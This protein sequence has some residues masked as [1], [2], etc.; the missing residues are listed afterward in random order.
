M[1]T[2]MTQET[3]TKLFTEMGFETESRREEFNRAFDAIDSDGN[4]LVD[5]M[6]KGVSLWVKIM[7]NITLS[8][9][10]GGCVYST[11]RS[12]AEEYTALEI[13]V[14]DEDG[15]LIRLEES[16]DDVV[17][18]AEYETILDVARRFDRRV[19]SR[20]TGPWR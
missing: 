20:P 12:F 19:P 9:Q 5:S 14:I 4:P 1:S 13:A 16:G 17:G 2:K 7:P 11:P 3:L 10:G 8:L 18:W 15:G 6:K